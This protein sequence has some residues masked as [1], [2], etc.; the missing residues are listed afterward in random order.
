MRS[1]SFLG[2][3]EF[4]YHV[5]L[6]VTEAWTRREGETWQEAAVTSGQEGQGDLTQKKLEGFTE[7]L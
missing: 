1:S 6:S 5:S 4:Q 7:S 2:V 3:A